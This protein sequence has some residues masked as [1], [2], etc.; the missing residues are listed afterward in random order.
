MLL[1]SSSSSDTAEGHD[2]RH[3]D[4][5]YQTTRLP[6]LLS[7]KCTSKSPHYRGHTGN[8]EPNNQR[9]PQANTQSLQDSHYDIRDH[10]RRQ[11][12]H[13]SNYSFPLTV[14]PDRQRSTTQQ[15]PSRPQA[16]PLT[17]RI[18]APCSH[19]VLSLVTS[20]PTRPSIWRIPAPTLAQCIN[21]FLPTLRSIAT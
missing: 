5:D 20:P 10:Y 3:D 11:H 4:D 16:D 6:F 13:R 15:G 19:L 18:A 9:Q 12:Q 17:Q 21:C 2:D 1:S 8:F 14:D 7:D